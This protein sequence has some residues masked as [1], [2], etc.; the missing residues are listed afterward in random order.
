MKK[1]KVEALQETGISAGLRKHFQTESAQHK[2]A[3]ISKATQT[4]IDKPEAEKIQHANK[5]SVTKQNWSDEKKKAF[6]ALKSEQTTTVLKNRS[7]L[8]QARI[9]AKQ[10]AS[11][12]AHYT[13]TTAEERSNTLRKGHA[14]RKAKAALD[15][16]A[17]ALKAFDNSCNSLLRKSVQERIIT[18]EQV[19]QCKVAL[20]RWAE[21]FFANE[22]NVT[23]DIQHLRAKARQK[24]V[25]KWGTVEQ[26]ALT[27]ILNFKSKIWGSDTLFSKIR[28]VASRVEL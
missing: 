1:N 7:T 11:L 22:D 5:E 4:W 15:P 12:N 18:Q 26:K 3:R 16:R 6:S 23:F 14:T 13:N 24:L 9:T 17:A 27:P 8:E 10:V 21:R 28:V 20:T 2:D 19:S 25:N